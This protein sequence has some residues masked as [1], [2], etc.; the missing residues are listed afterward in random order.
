MKKIFQQLKHFDSECNNAPFAVLCALILV[1]IILLLAPSCGV[2][3]K[4][5]VQKEVT[6]QI[7]FRYDN[8]NTYEIIKIDG[9][10]YVKGW[11]GVG[12]GGPY[13]THKG[14][15]KN[16]IHAYIKPF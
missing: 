2:S 8:N 15:C 5:N 16:P 12:N 4:P 11:A 1:F 14:N 10:E 13:L 3:E 9:C 7:N 6:N